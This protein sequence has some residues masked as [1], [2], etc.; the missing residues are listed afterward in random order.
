MRLHVEVE[1]PTISCGN[2]ALFI[3][4]RGLDEFKANISRLFKEQGTKA[5]VLVYEAE[6]A[7]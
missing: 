5:T 6:R 2:N 7:G 3:S 4:Y 1:Q